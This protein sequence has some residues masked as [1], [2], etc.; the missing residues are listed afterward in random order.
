MRTSILV[1][2]IFAATCVSA[3]TNAEKIK[4]KW[5]VDRFV[6]EKNT[7][8]AVKVKQDLQSVCLSFGENE[9]V[10]SK[11]TDSGDSV[12]KKGPYS[13]SGNT[14]TLGKDHAEISELSEKN[15]TIKLPGQATLYLI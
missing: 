1:I 10:I 13:I 15:L 4:A 2:F 11:K 5:I 3:Q 7:P 8:Q 12:I 9:L 6:V 14:L